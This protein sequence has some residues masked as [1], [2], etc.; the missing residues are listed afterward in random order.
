MDAKVE[1][2][3]RQIFADL[4]VDQEESQ[5]LVDFFSKANPPPDKLVW[6]RATAFRLGCEFL[7][8]DK[9]RNV[10]LLRAINAI[11]HALEKTCMNPKSPYGNCEYDGDKVEAFYKDIF[12]DLSV[13]MEENEKLVEF[14]E[15]NVPPQSNLVSLRATAFK[16]AVDY[17]GDD[18]T[19]NV[20]LLRCINVVVHNL[21]QNIFKPKEYQLKLAPTFDLDVSLSDAIQ[22]MWDLDINRLTP[23]VDYKLDVQGGKKPYWKDDA[24]RDPLFTYVDKQ[25]LR[26]PTYKAFMALMD[27]YKAE[28]GQ[29]ETVTSGERSENWTFLKAIMQTAP[30]QL[31]HKYLRKKDPSN[32]PADQSAFLKLVYKIWFDLY[33][34]SRGARNDSSGF[35]HVFVG[36]VK[37]G[38]VTGFHNWIQFY[39]EEQKGAL[40]YRGYI[41]PRSHNEAHADSDDHV[42][43]LQFAW[44]G[45]EKFVGTSFIGVSPE[46]EMALYTTCFLL[47]DEE[48][49]IVLK[50]RTDEFHLK[51]KCYKMAR[52][53]IG[54]SFPEATAHYD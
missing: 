36:E 6:L 34:R 39:M 17:L 33:N 1:T 41:K 35:E 3:Y 22:Q 20:A 19:S 23:N 51:I 11:I 45:V 9:D 21:E 12:S 49:D 44:N 24:A 13:D 15:N 28:C 27:N 14:F 30:M 42:L 7:S 16:A 54:T 29:T 26:R 25:C 53:H 47:G 10:A 50:T 43:T 4:V 37:D 52:D 5:Q 2:F 32:I 31:C 46:F 48:N 38:S 40:D 8:D 18:K